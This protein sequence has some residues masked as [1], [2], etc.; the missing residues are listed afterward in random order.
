MHHMAGWGMAGKSEAGRQ[1]GPLQR[2]AADDKLY[3][4]LQ[5]KAGHHVTQNHPQRCACVGLRVDE[6]LEHVVDDTVQVHVWRTL[7]QRRGVPAVEHLQRQLLHDGKGLR[8]VRSQPVLNL[9]IGCQVGA[10]YGDGL[11]LDEAHHIDLLS[12]SDDVCDDETHVEPQL[13]NK[14]VVC[15]SG[16]DD[17]GGDSTLPVVNNTTA[18]RPA[19]GK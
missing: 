15:S 5:Y 14:I 3:R 2:T 4:R 11:I 10:G 16:D 17:G 12:P 7:A 13:G 6:M 18:Q 8:V 9:M 1:I 19:R